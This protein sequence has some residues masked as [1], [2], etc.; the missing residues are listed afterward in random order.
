[1]VPMYPVL[2]G[3]IAKRGIKKKDIASS[4][5]VCGK[6]L[7]NKLVGRS[8]FTWSQIEKIRANFFPDMTPEQ[9]LARDAEQKG[10]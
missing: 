2:S 4:I 6:A 3:E 9:L 5:G 7:S 8:E 1:M 10:A